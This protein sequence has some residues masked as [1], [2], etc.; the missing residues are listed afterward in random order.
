MVFKNR[1]ALG[2]PPAGFSSRHIHVSIP[3][4]STAV[5]PVDACVAIATQVRAGVAAPP[6]RVTCT[7]TGRWGG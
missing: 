7:G 1:V 3:H 4:M 5:M 6:R 2:N